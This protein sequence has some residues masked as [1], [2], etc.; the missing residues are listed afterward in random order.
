LIVV[1]T[2]DG[3]ACRHRPFSIL[4]DPWSIW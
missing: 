4:G 3:K 2:G 1:F